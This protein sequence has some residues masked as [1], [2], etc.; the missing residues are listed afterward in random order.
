MA[1]NA[2]QLYQV[3]IK[4]GMMKEDTFFAIIDHFNEL[5]W[6]DRNRYGEE[7]RTLKDR[8]AALECAKDSE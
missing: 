8:I 5:H 2:R 1:N 7:I 6:H 3:Y 4:R